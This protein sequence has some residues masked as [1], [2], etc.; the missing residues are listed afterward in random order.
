V[1]AV[2]GRLA[3]LV[4][5]RSRHSTRI[6]TAAAARRLLP[7]DWTGPRRV[8]GELV[9][10]NLRHSDA[11]AVATWRAGR[12]RTAAAL[13]LAVGLWSLGSA[14]SSPAPPDP[15]GPGG[16][17]DSLEEQDTL[18]TALTVNLAERKATAAITARPAPGAA[19]LRFEVGNLT[20]LRVS[21][22]GEPLEAKVENGELRVE[23]PEV[24]EAGAA[25]TL[26]IEYGLQ[27]G[28]SF[29]GLLPSGATFIWP[30]FCGNLFPCRS[31]PRDGLT[32]RLSLQ[33]VPEGQIAVFPQTIAADAPPYM[34]AWAVGAYQHQEI[35][36]TTAGTRLHVYF[37]PGEEKSA[38]A[39]TKGL[40]KF[41][42]RFERTLGPYA[43]GPDAGSVSV[44]WGP[45]AYG[46]MEHHPYWH[47]SSSSIGEQ[48]VHVHEA[49]HGWFGNGV[50]IRCWEDFVLSEG[51]TSYITA[52]AIGAVNGTFAERRVWS[53]YRTQ[54]D[55]AVRDRDAIA[56]PDSCG[57]VD[58]LKDGLFSSIPYMKGA[59]F[60]KAVA[61]RV[62]AEKLD[63]V[64]GSFYQ[65]HV[66]AAQGM[67]DLLDAIR[68]ETGFDP[69]PLAQA[70]LRSL[71]VPA[72]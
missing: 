66:G 63:R 8:S 10:L 22:G 16:K 28:A 13:A 11:L 50:R 18:S 67:G 61:D 62:G 9:R 31:N 45:G 68:D 20:D 72:A 12:G 58:V 29:D 59:L 23:L 38:P 60:L 54:L 70:W 71:G 17:A 25:A 26:S 55:T 57:Q 64:L 34:L 21:Q 32:F 24:G 40:E 4:G 69:W 56:W 2:A 52:R 42:D 39:A 7:L 6:R 36:R 49:G 37:L 35:G 48:E 46:G 27:H 65:K 30:Y 44:A 19:E 43:F 1:R 41:F 5:R 14:C 33:G 47:I 15:T 51:T 3:T 53:R